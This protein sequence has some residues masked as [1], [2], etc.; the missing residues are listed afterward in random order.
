MLCYECGC[1]Y[2]TR[3]FLLLPYLLLSLSPRIRFLCSFY[4]A[5]NGVHI[6]KYIYIPLM[7]LFPF[8]SLSTCFRLWHCQ[9]THLCAYTRVCISWITQGL[10]GFHTINIYLRLFTLSRHSAGSRNPRI[11]I[12]QYTVESIAS[13]IY[14]PHIVALNCVGLLNRI[15][16]SKCASFVISHIVARTNE[17]TYAQ[18]T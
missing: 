3:M 14:A 10:D 7:G 4:L 13:G 17:R 2:S 1:V 15:S 16:P 12:Q 8:F 6:H 18:P 9:M 11:V 5:T